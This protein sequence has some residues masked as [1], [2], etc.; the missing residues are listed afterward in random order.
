[1]LSVQP[2]T[3]VQ[4][5][6][7]TS[8]SPRLT[9]MQLHACYKYFHLFS[10]AHALTEN[11]A[12]THLYLRGCD[13]GADGLA[14]LSSSLRNKSCL[15]LLGMSLNKF[16]SEGAEYLGRVQLNRMSSTM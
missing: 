10:T 8:Y 15:Q 4:L 14:L 1:M 9:C 16:G 3:H 12:L 2:C 7:S 6:A 11:T 13:I 5:V